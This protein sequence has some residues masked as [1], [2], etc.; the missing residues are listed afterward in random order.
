MELL[1]PISISQYRDVR[2]EDGHWSAAEQMV[3]DF[4]KFGLQAF[5]DRDRARRR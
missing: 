1:Y 3:Q 2:V 5:M 4:K